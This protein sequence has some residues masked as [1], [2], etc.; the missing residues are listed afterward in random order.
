MRRGFFG[1]I[2]DY[3]A[4]QVLPQ[5]EEGIKQAGAKAEEMV[6]GEGGKTLQN[7]VLEHARDD[8]GATH[9]AANGWTG[10]EPPKQGIG[11]KI[12]DHIMDRVLPEVGDMLMQKT[13]Q[14]AAELSMA[15]NHQSTAYQPYGY[16][17]KP[18]QPHEVEG[19]QQSYQDM[20][21][22]ASERQGPEQEKGIDR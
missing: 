7:R 8:L 14:G 1:K 3:L 19:P 17:Q 9:N 18:L 13:A 21:R 6:K 5:M 10:Y 12:V 22:Q 11:G 15:L 4:G 16:A 2:M 20:L